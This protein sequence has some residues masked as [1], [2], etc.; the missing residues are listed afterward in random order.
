M[1]LPRCFRSFV[2]SKGDFSEY[3]LQLIQ[4]SFESLQSRLSNFLGVDRLGHDKEGITMH[5]NFLHPQLI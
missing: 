5:D 1:H 3:T 2:H 4:P